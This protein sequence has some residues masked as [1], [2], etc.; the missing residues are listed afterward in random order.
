[1]YLAPEVEVEAIELRNIIA[2]SP[3]VPVNTDKEGD[4]SL[5]P[6]KESFDIWEE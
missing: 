1:M 4:P 2:A 6:A 3:S 5:S